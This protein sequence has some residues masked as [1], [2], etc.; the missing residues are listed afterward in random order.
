MNVIGVYAGSISTLAAYLFLTIYR[1]FDVRKFQA[2]RY[3]WEK[4]VLLNVGLVIMCAFCWINIS[5]TNILNFILGIVL[6]VIV[7][8]NIIR[9]LLRM[10][11]EKIHSRYI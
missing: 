8:K 2:I 11:N 6:A 4:F 9:A 1:M 5:I 7:N 3:R 10:I